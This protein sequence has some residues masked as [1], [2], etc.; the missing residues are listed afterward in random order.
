MTSGP[1]GAG[2]ASPIIDV[3]TAAMSAADI[4][5]PSIVW[6]SAPYAS[7]SASVASGADATIGAPASSRRRVTFTRRLR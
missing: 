2:T 5:C 1:S 4:M 7:A 3:W 6:E